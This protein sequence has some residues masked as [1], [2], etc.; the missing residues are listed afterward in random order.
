[1]HMGAAEIDGWFAAGPV[2]AAPGGAIVPIGAMPGGLT[3][4]QT[5]TWICKNVLRGKFYWVSGA[6]AVFRQWVTD[7]NNLIVPG[8]NTSNLPNNS[9]LW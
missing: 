3:P 4:G 1:M 5:L 9:L 7:P 8:A 6:T 2:G